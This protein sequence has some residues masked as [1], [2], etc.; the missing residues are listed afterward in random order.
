LHT[1]IQVFPSILLPAF[2]GLDLL[3]TTDNPP[4]AVPSIRLSLLG[5]TSS[6]LDTFV[7]RSLQSFPRSSTHSVPSI[8]TLITSVSPVGLFPLLVFLQDVP[9][10]QASPF[11]RRVALHYRHLWFTL[12]SG[13]DF[14][15]RPFRFS[16]TGDTLS[17]LL[18]WKLGPLLRL[19][20]FKGESYR[21]DLNHLDCAT[22]GH[23]EKPG[24]RPVLLI[25]SSDVS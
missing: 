21:V 8:L 4:P 9:S 5:Y 6:T 19:R 2:I 15:C 16:L 14:A 7:P 13:L 25:F 11:F 24:I 23:T 1:F 22:A 17:V 18:L 20:H 12:H 3:T 10:A